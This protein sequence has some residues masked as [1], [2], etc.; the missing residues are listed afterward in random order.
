MLTAMIGGAFAQ[1]PPGGN[2]HN[3]TVDTCCGSYTW[4]V[5]G[6]TYHASGVYTHGYDTL[7]L[8]IYSL[9]TVQITGSSYPTAQSAN[10]DY[11]CPGGTV[12]LTASGA[13]SCYLWSNDST[14]ASISVKYS[15]IFSV[16]GVVYTVTG[17]DRHGCTATASDTVFLV[18][19]PNVTIEGPEEVC[20][21]ESFMLSASG[22]HYYSWDEGVA[23][24]PNYTVDYAVG[25]VNNYTLV[26]SDI[27]GCAY[28]YIKTVR[29]APTPEIHVTGPDEIC[30]GDP[31][32]L[33]AT[34]LVSCVWK[35]ESHFERR[36]C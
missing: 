33:S 20:P 14:T 29:L 5:N 16:R 27:Y 12:V 3:V 13:D 21:L 32:T 9:P 8:T 15:D 18:Q 28:T 23:T 17:T 34:N 35:K 24:T 22:A 10:H 6:Q 31:A 25:S 19:R 7:H 11:V 30:S 1:T 4:S 26:A 36:N 2:T